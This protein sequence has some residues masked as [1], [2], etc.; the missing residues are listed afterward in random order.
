MSREH[1]EVPVALI[2]VAVLTSAALS[3]AW[4]GDD[5]T[6]TWRTVTNVLAGHGARWN[7]VERVQSYTHPL[8]MILLVGI[9]GAGLDLYLGSLGLS[10]ALTVA[11]ASV[12]ALRAGHRLSG[13]LVVLLLA[14]SRPFVDFSTGGLETPLTFLLLILF[15]LTVLRRSDEA[16]SDSRSGLFLPCALAGM[17]VLNR[18]DTL[19]VIGPALLLLLVRARAWSR[20]GPVV[21]GFLPLIAWLAFAVLY[22]GHPLPN[23]AFAKLNLPFGRGQTLAQGWHYVT[24]GA[25]LDPVTLPLLV[26]GVGAGLFLGRSGARALAGGALASVVYTVWVGGDFMRGRFLTPA[27]VVAALLLDDA[28]HRRDPRFILGAL[29]L[30]GLLLFAYPTSP[31][32]TGQDYAD[33]MIDDWG[34]ADERGFFYQ[35]SG[36]FASRRVEAPAQAR[37]EGLSP[38]VVRIGGGGAIPFVARPSTHLVDDFALTD[39]LIARLPPAN[40]G[41]FRPGHVRREVPAGYLESLRR[42]TN[43]IEDPEVA[44]LWDD[45]VLVTQ[46]PLFAPDRAGA[47][48]RTLTGARRIQHVGDRLEGARV[49]AAPWPQPRLASE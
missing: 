46:A 14:S 24:E 13:A 28:L 21:A 31:L 38:A 20:P 23:T 40:S 9:R 49:T 6:I 43:L 15:G 42:R 33:E 3:T 5:P 25:H 7:I 45:L 27:L 48:W 34:L 1:I 2:A 44:R 8:W 39:P 10:I 17:L 4:L 18:L 41:P 12:V 35:W 37:T 26:V 29:P 47:I 32:R 22:Y 11:S 19:F 30:A 36:L 16:A